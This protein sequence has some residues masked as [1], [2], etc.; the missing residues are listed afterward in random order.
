MP[1]DTW[2]FWLFQWTDSNEA[3]ILKDILSQ[4]GSQWIIRILSNEVVSEVNDIISDYL[5]EH[6]TKESLATISSVWF[7]IK[8]VLWSIEQ[9]LKWK[10][11]HKYFRNTIKPSLWYRLYINWVL[12]KLKLSGFDPEKHKY[13]DVPTQHGE[14][15]F[16]ILQDKAMTSF[17][18]V[19][20]SFG[21]LDFS[22]NEINTY[23]EENEIKVLDT[24]RREISNGLYNW[25]NW[26]NSLHVREHNEI[27]VQDEYYDDVNLR[28]DRQKVWTWSKRSLRVR[29]KIDLETQEIQTLYTIKR[30]IDESQTKNKK[31][32]IDSR[33]CFEKEF[34]I[35]EIEVFE[36]FLENVWLKK[37][38]EKSKKR[39]SYSISFKYKKKIVHAKLDIDDYEN[40][41]PE[42][43]EIECDD[44]DA[45]K[46]IIWK[47]KLWKK[48]LLTDGSR[49][50][51]E[52]YG[53]NEQYK[54]YYSVDSDWIVHWQDGNIWDIKASPPIRLRT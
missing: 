27:D 24:S 38:R 22:Q 47:L 21:L 41:I 40:G 48:T 29:K 25:Q 28:L 32:E 51:F 42:F 5:R 52:H 53:L 34:E 43:L 23:E 54:R 1:L 14:D 45:I 50:L 4:E 37:S 9:V 49:W 46:Y 44:N 19:A 13:S 11:V 17:F 6:S 26:D 18:M 12:E 7:E 35:N 30:K 3:E 10:I 36:W 2:P 39:K 31:K 15:I 20:K 16:N 8:K 33:K